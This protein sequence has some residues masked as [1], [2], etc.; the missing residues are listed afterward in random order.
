MEEEKNTKEQL[1]EAAVQVFLD[2][3]FEGAS[4]RAICKKAGV[5]TGALYFFFEN[6]EALFG[7]IVEPVLKQLESLRQQLMEEELNN[8]SLGQEADR[9]MMEY[10]WHNRR[11]I[12]LLLE[13]SKG[14]RYETVSDGIFSQM[15]EAFSIFFQ[16]YGNMGK[17]K[18]LIRI[19][20][21]MRM[22]GYLEL[23]TG[24][25]S[26]DE[27]LRLAEMVGCYADGGFRNLMRCY[28]KG[29]EFNMG[30]L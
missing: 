25:Y 2:K 8:I 30:G 9:K 23:I 29:N 28:G 19:L 13:K 1:I 10:L 17:D 20:V 15:E 26:R 16:R 4:L 6:K 24:E 3:G 18:N 11:E 27:V 5:T 21:K 14:T 22:Q 12:R 7:S